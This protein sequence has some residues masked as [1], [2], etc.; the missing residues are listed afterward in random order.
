M[1]DPALTQALLAAP[2]PASWSRTFPATPGQVRQARQF[3]ALILGDS[4]ALA[5]ALACLSELATNAVLHSHS[6][7]PGGHFTLR[8]ILTQGVLRAEIED[9]GGPW[10]HRTSPNGQ[11][12]RGLTIVNALATAWGRHTS[13]ASRTVWFTIDWP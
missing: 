7:R 4:P 3:L 9:E 2:A 1:P 13:G 11:S 10:H 5:D 12:G 8:A 6:S